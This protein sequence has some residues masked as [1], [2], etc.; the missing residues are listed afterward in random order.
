MRSRACMSNSSNSCSSSSCRHISR[1]CKGSRIRSGGGGRE[2]RGGEGGGGGGRVGRM[3]MVV[4]AA[5]VVHLFYLFH[6]CV[7]YLLCLFACL[8]ICKV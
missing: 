3:V 4:A 2:G 7:L 6:S 1:D 5:A 8:L